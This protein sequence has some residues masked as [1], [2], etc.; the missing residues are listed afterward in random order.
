MV[1]Q[2]K[3][4]SR[5]GLCPTSG[6]SKAVDVIDVHVLTETYHTLEVLDSKPTAKPS[7]SSCIDRAS[8]MSNP[9]SAAETVSSTS[10]SLF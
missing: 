4:F 3:T 10:G 6:I 5:S 8:T 2:A 9:L 7:K 1:Q